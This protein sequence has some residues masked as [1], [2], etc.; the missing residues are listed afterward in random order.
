MNIFFF[1]SSNVFEEEWN[2]RKANE[3]A[4]SPVFVNCNNGEEIDRQDDL[5]CT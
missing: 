4:V 1:R 2:A 5:M 3:T